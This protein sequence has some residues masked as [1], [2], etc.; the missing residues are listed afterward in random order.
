MPGNDLWTMTHQSNV[1]GRTGESVYINAVHLE[2]DTSDVL[3]L[4]FYGEMI[5]N[6]KK[7]AQKNFKFHNSFPTFLQIPA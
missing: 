4:S 6:R 5:E 7:E 3:H 1:P 2:G